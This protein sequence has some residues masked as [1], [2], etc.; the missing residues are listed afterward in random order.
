MKNI[1]L[2]TAIA[3]LLPISLLSCASKKFDDKSEKVLMGYMESMAKGDYV[4]A[5]DS[6][7]PVFREKLS[8]LEFKSG[9]ENS[10]PKYGNIVGGKIEGK[11][12]METSNDYLFDVVI[13]YDKALVN[14]K[15][16]ML[17]EGGQWYINMIR[18]ISFK[19]NLSDAA[20]NSSSDAVVKRSQTL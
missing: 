16:E 20:N 15:I 2:Y 4:D 19:R 5:Y 13:V 11:V 3:I 7:H 18:P 14:Y 10:K 9:I 8:F 1:V 17:N 6:L 12:L